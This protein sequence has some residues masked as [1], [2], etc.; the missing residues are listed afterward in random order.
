MKVNVMCAHK[1]E[2]RKCCVFYEVTCKLCGD[3]YVGNNQNR[4]KRM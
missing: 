3:F 1:G 2:C 4:Q